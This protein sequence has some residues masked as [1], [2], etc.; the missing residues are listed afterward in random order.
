MLLATKL[1]TTELLNE[2]AADL[3]SMR[4]IGKIQGDA[5]VLAHRRQYT[6]QLTTTGQVEC[7]QSHG[8]VGV[9]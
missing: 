1:L 7:K 8:V 4:S 3:D 9:Q 5:Q 2:R 6:R